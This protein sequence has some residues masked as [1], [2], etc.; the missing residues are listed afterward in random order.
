MRV[1]VVIGTRP[2]AIKL[3]P[4]VMALR[5]A[6]EVACRVVAAA[7]HRELL[8]RALA[9]FGIAADVDL[10]LMRPSQ[11]LAGLTARAVEGLDR[12]IGEGRPDVVLVQGDTTTAFCGAL[13]AFYRRVEVGHVEAGLRT[14]DLAAPWPEEANRSLIAR[15]ARWHFAPT[16][17]AAAN[18]RRE[19]IDGSRIVVTGNTGIDALLWMRER[20][21]TEGRAGL[22]EW[23]DE[24]RGRLVL[25]TVHRRE[26]FGGALRSV[27]G[28]IAELARRYATDRFVVP[29]HP[30]PEVR[31][32]AEA[33]MGGR[34]PNVRLVEPIGYREMVAALEASALVLTDSGGVQEEAPTF[35]VPVLVL[36]SATER[37]EAVEAGCSRVVGVEPTRIVAA[38]SR[39]LETGERFAG[40]NPY[41]DG[42]AAGR[43]VEALRGARS[44][45]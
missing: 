24:E 15:M 8:D 34:M 27:F 36:R 2:E 19:G 23:I 32:A 39:V 17:R 38:A 40:T 31:A 4:V 28:A 7:Q 41:G 20:L 29:L 5:G 1:D 6:R 37:P 13:A 9:D 35:G 18:L 22:P 11:T 44:P 45:G 12:A 30:N 26:H 3:A 21:R 10:D 16:E 42:R 33:A 43:I 25:V 14:G